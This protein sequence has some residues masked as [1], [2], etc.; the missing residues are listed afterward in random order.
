RNFGLASI[1]DLEKVRSLNG[2]SSASASS[3]MLSS[4]LFSSSDASSSGSFANL[5][6]TAEKL[7][8]EQASSK[9]DLD[10]A[11]SKVKRLTEQI[12]ILEEKLQVA[13]NENSK[14]KVKQNE[15]EKLWKG[16]ESKFSSTKKHCDQL[17]ETLNQ[18]NIQVQ[19]AEKDKAFIEDKLHST[20]EVLGGL[21]KHINSLSSRLE[22]SEN[23]IKTRDK[24]LVELGL[25]K[26]KAVAY[27]NG[28][29]I[30]AVSLIEEKADGIIK[31]LEEDAAENKMVMDDLLSELEK[32]HLDI[33]VKQDDLLSLNVLK[34]KLERENKELLAS[35]GD[36]T[37]R[38]EI[39]LKDIKNLECFVELLVK[40]LIELENQ[41]L[42]FSEKMKQLISFYDS[43]LEL[44][45]NEKDLVS[46][47]A[48][49]KFELL[50]NDCARLISE[51]KSMQLI[52]HEL[53]SRVL[54]LQKEQ[55]FSM[56]QHAEECRLADE[57]IRKLE[58]DAEVL[59][60][61]NT[62]MQ[63]LIVKLEDNLRIASENSALS[64]K[65]MQD[66]MLKHS[67]LERETIDLR[68]DIMKKQGE[69]DQLL[70]EGQKS[71]EKIESLEKKLNDSEI[72]LQEGKLIIVE[73]TNREKQ[74]ADQ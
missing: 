32:L 17:I 26:E 55:E 35:Q 39:A 5:K 40:K 45:Q 62:G 27:F 44:A 10:I 61:R 22:S 65:K 71:E 74:F 63:E 53:N 9:A 38:H 2:S 8:R 25:A 73:L 13:F 18:L 72:A 36:L 47:R 30:K 42:E 43:C 14:L 70:N 49:Q 3:K 56:V 12:H 7:V 24:E 20:S 11:K 57:K 46:T 29:Q 51:N 1:K 50:Q 67:K 54:D 68:T 41:S 15:D 4:S 33:K 69:I 19:Q 66:L 37:S 16:L 21:Q 59:F 52:N 60:S 6:F 28:E 23:T 58:S 31:R 34:E 64:D 48:G